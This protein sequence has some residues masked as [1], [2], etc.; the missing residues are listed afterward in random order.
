MPKKDPPPDWLPKPQPVIQE[1][2]RP[3]G[4]EAPKPSVPPPT[5]DKNVSSIH[6]IITQEPWISFD[7][8]GDPNPEGFKIALFLASGSSFK[9]VYGDGTIEINMYRVI[10]RRDKKKARVLIKKWE[11]DPAG[12]L[13]YLLRRPT[14]Y[15][16]GYGFRLNWGD[17]E[18]YGKDVMIVCRFIRA[19]NQIIT[20]QPR[21]LKVPGRIG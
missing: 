9:G 14:A 17:A 7:E 18:V 1:T 13:P 5:P 8:E 3:K 21:W 2:N 16:W 19:D 20:G 4:P 11:F 12:A 10:T 15:G 6:M